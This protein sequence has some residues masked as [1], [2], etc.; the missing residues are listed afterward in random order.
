[1]LLI[2]NGEL[3]YS[4]GPEGKEIAYR[5]EFIKEKEELIA[6]NEKFSGWKH[7]AEEDDQ[8]GMVSRG[9]LWGGRRQRLE[10][11]KIV[12]GQQVENG[13]YF[14]IRMTRASGLFFYNPARDEEIRHFHREHFNPRG[15][16]V[17]GETLVAAIEDEDHT[18][19]IC[20]FDLNGRDPVSLTSGDALDEHPSIHGGQVVYS[21]AGIARD[22]N[23]V[24]AKLAPRAICEV[25]V[26]GS[27]HRVLRESPTYDYILP[28]RDPEGRLYAIRMPYVQASYGF[29]Q[30]VKDVAL[31]PINLAIAIMGFLNVFSI[32]FGKR[33]IVPSGGP[34]VEAQDL[35]KKMIHARIVNIQS[36]S[37]KAGF[38]VAAPSTWVLVRI[39]QEQ[40]TVLDNHVVGFAFD[41]DGTLLVNKG[42]HISAL[43]AKQTVHQSQDLISVVA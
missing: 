10:I 23:G 12:D 36:E 21:S 9:M 8:A 32:M 43:A 3:T 11:P 18:R 2:K 26:D 16:C 29:V 6:R 15:F 33:P 27:S 5:S 38:R 14:I 20:R 40:D 42:Y 13:F 31:F 41:R 7:A 39:D 4:T 30:F 28:K 24:P 35:R 22:Q 25:S 19:H 37:K 1:M 34:R 17:A